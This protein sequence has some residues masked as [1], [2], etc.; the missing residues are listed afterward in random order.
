M[1]D[2]DDNHAF[3]YLNREINVYPKSSG[4]VAY[5]TTGRCNKISID[6]NKTQNGGL[7]SVLNVLML[8][9]DINATNKMV[10]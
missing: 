4:T 10:K 8:P 5:T 6:T 9:R 1:D 2:D 7:S 3:F